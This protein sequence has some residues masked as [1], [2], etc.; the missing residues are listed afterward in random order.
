MD[1]ETKWHCKVIQQLCK[2]YGQAPNETDSTEGGDATGMNGSGVSAATTGREQESSWS[3]DISVDAQMALVNM[4]NVQRR[5]TGRV[6]GGVER[7][8]WPR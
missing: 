1:A 4:E 6:D 7:A 5:E 2:N 8:P 3:G